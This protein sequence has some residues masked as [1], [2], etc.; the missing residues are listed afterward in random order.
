MMGEIVV[1]RYVWR[2]MS[3]AVNGSSTHLI[4]R[5]NG[6]ALTVEGVPLIVD[7]Q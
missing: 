1:N 3:W 7:V 2:G 5:W 6:A 4:D